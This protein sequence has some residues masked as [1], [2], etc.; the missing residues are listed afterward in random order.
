M[1]VTS[2]P[3]QILAQIQW[4]TVDKFRV[5]HQGNRLLSSGAYT[6]SLQGLGSGV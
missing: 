1:P 4:F 2:G 3:L 6:C 5:I